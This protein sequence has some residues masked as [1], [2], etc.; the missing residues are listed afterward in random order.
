MMLLNP[1]KHWAHHLCK[2]NNKIWGR[3]NTVPFFEILQTFLLYFDKRKFENVQRKPAENNLFTDVPRLLGG[4]EHSV[5]Q[6]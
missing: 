3:F 1:A 2:I 5:I 6:W 4:V